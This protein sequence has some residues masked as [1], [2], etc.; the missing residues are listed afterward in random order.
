M[1]VILFI[2][3]TVKG[4]ATYA[5]DGL[6]FVQC[7][8]HGV[9][10]WIPPLI[11]CGIK[12]LLTVVTADHTFHVCEPDIGLTCPPYRQDMMDDRSH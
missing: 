8:S 1:I 12:T 10:L 7:Q 6:G 11:L 5:M 9:L 2:K 3:A 4:T